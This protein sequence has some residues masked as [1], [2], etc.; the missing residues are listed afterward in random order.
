MPR[1]L[2]S[3]EG[4]NF[5][6]TTMIAEIANTYY[7]LMALD[8][9]LDIINQSIEI[10]TNGFQVVQQQKNAAKVTQLAVNRFE[11]QLLH[12]KNLQYDVRQRIVEAENKI[13]FL[14]GGSAII[15]TRNSAAF[16]NLAMDSVYSG[17]PSQ[18]LSSRPDIRQAEFQL[19]AAKLDVK[20]ARANFYPS[21]RITAGAGFQAFNPA[22]IVKPESIL[23]HL[24]EIW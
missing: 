20:V 2:A 21:F 15:I 8:N 10:Q 23:Y 1:Y 5:S 17:I 6:K 12:T 24:R 9:L 13:R 7:E 11:A 18:L 14:T 19:Q 16:S 22:Y 4:R 3:T